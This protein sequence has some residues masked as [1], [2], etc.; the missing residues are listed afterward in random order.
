MKKQ[1][2]IKKLTP[3]EVLELFTRLLT[4]RVSIDTEFILSGPNDDIT[5][6]VLRIKCEGLELVSSPEQ[7]QHSL[8]FANA[9]DFNE[10]VH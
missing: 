2:N 1:I 7:L 6:Q 4:E 8:R 3:Q 5:H 10:K 9:D